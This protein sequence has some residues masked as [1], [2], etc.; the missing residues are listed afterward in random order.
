MTR[1][2][3]V[4]GDR[5]CLDVTK[6]TIPSGRFLCVAG[7][8]PDQDGQT[9]I[10]SI[11][12]QAPRN[13]SESSNALCRHRT[14][15][16]LTDVDTYE[17]VPFVGDL[18]RHAGRPPSRVPPVGRSPTAMPARANNS[19]SLSEGRG[20]TAS[21]DRASTALSVASEPPYSRLRSELMRG[22]LPRGRAVSDEQVPLS[23]NR[24]QESPTPSSAAPH[25][26][27]ELIRALRH[28]R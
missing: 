1:D 22:N 6:L 27:S 12:G 23:H 20:R 2:Y 15:R 19:Q 24:A 8:T 13:V 9:T 26:R 7:C 14:R 17:T 4:S 18:P 16:R 10:V 21:P 5:R 28:G 25:V 3:S 11:I